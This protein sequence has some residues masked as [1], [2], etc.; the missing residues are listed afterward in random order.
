MNRCILAL[1][2]LLVAVLCME[3][4]Q[5]HDQVPFV[6]CTDDSNCCCGQTCQPHPSVEGVSD[7]C[8]CPAG[9]YWDSASV[10]CLL[11][12]GAESSTGTSCSFD[13]DCASGETCVDNICQ[14]E[15][16]ETAGAAALAP[17][18]AAIVLLGTL[19][20]L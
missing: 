17:Q 10:L 11:R 14:A 13:S 15:E 7:F 12:E 5:A 16:S 20:F 9:K 4:A 1:G 2:T 19:Y 8:Q 18:I 3:L 6:V